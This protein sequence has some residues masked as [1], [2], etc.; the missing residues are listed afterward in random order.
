M[1]QY[2]FNLI[3][4]FAWPYVGGGLSF[5]WNNIQIDRDPVIRSTSS[6]NRNEIGLGMEGAIGINF[7]LIQNLNL[8]SEIKIR[9]SNASLIT[10]ESTY[11]S[12]EFTGIYFQLG[13]GYS[14]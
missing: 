3:F 9:V 8:L 12:I 6:F 11:G 4:D 10:E 1:Y 13:L 7:K 14:L 2:N 5:Y